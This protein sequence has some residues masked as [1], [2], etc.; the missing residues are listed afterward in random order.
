MLQPCKSTLALALAKQL[1]KLMS[2][3]IPGESVGI[4]SYNSLVLSTGLDLD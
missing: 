4:P 1:K 3:N 2:E